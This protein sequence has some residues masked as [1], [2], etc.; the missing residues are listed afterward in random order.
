[1]IATPDN[2]SLVTEVDADEVF[3]E[4]SESYEIVLPGSRS[5]H[6]CATIVLWGA[7]ESERLTGRRNL[8]SWGYERVLPLLRAHGL[9]VS[10]FST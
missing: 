10:R 9:S 5:R 4:T 1:M 3:R 8:C 2:D 6:C 7:V